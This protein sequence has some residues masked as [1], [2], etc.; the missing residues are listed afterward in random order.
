MS[1][2]IATDNKIIKK[3]PGMICCYYILPVK[4][5]NM[6]VYKLPTPQEPFRWFQFNFIRKNIYLYKV[7][8]ATL[9]AIFMKLINIFIVRTIHNMLSHW[10]VCVCCEHVVHWEIRKKVWAQ[11]YGSNA[12]ELSSKMKHVFNKHTT[13]IGFHWEKVR[14]EY[15]IPCMCVIKYWRRNDVIVDS[16]VLL[17]NGIVWTSSNLLQISRVNY[18]AMKFNSMANQFWWQ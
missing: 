13:I 10:N 5:S 16:Q 7:K 2:N 14:H 8:S 1:F 9:F 18:R 3:T 4:M 15:V 11:L 17:F 12:G 6:F